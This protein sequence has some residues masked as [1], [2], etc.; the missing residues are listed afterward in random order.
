MM[1][2][3]STLMNSD[4]LLWLVYDA[5]NRR[6]LCFADLSVGSPLCLLCS[7]VYDRQSLFIKGALEVQN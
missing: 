4:F 6:Y 2:R 7:S 3:I 1:Q 5:W